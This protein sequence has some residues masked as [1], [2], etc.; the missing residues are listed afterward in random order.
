MHDMNKLLFY[1]KIHLKEDATSTCK[2]KQ[3]SSQTLTHRLLSKD[4]TM[5]QPPPNADNEYIFSPFV[6]TPQ[7]S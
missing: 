3:S 2:E 1:G 6:E 7:R 5:S 4:S